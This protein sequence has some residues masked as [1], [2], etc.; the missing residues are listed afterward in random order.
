LFQD[1]FGTGRINY[2]FWSIATE[3]HIYFFMPLFVW[4]WRR[5]GA[6][7]VVTMTM[8]S[9]YAVA[10]AFA[11]TRVA[12]ANVHF[13]GMFTLGMLAAYVAQSKD[14]LF[15][16]LRERFPFRL[17]ALLAF[18]SVVGLIAWFG[19]QQSIRRFLILDFP[20]GILATCL[21]V[22]GAKPNSLL[23]RVF[24]FG[25]LAFVGTFSYSV[26]LVHAPF[27]QLEWQFVLEPLGLSRD[28]QFLTMGSIGLAVIV[29]ASYGF[30]RLF[31]APFMSSPKAVP[32]TA[33]VA[34]PSV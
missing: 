15:E 5:F 21:L 9:G 18:A 2:V 16:R 23:G 3:W 29:G 4:A 26:Y 22:V 12:R 19:L 14:P 25:P 28:A 20:V 6:A 8:L 32:K 24:S 7:P 27:L 31:E 34:K 10:I 11:D 30:H 13:L 17:V 33:M 1:F